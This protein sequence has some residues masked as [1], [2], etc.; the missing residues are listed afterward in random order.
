[1]MALLII[2]QNNQ[3]IPKKISK[4]IVYLYKENGGQA[5]ARNLGLKY[6][7]KIYKPWV[8]LLIRDFLD[9]NYFYEVINF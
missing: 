1:M 5:S 4:N 2:L 7:K 6:I 3:K 8:T 9:R